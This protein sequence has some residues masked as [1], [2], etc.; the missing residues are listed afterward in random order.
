MEQGVIERRTAY[1]ISVMHLEPLPAEALRG[2][3]AKA[4][5]AQPPT[6]PLHDT[7]KLDII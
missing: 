5:C 1:E 6:K 4:A 7:V 3:P 2:E